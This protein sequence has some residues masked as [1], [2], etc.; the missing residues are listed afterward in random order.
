MQ[1]RC[2][3]CSVILNVMVTHYTCSLN[4][5][6]CPHR[7][8]QWC[9]HCSH[10]H[11]PVHSPWLPGY[12]DVAQTVLVILTMEWL[13]FFRTDLICSRRRKKHIWGRK[14]E[15]KGSIFA[16]GYNLEMFYKEVT[17]WG[18][19][20]KWRLVRW[21]MNLRALPGAQE[22]AERLNTVLHSLETV[23]CLMW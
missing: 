9:H 14:Q 8:V 22:K 6:Y 11:I 12:I 19:K 21:S 13:D 4:G 18:M 10:M 20:D 5:I 16:G 23:T 15:R 1:I 7:L 2:S 3:T 17:L